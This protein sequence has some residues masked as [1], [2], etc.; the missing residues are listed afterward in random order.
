MID[1][2]QLLTSNSQ[3]ARDN[4]QV[5]VAEISRGIKGLALELKIPIIVM[6]QINRK[7]EEGNGEPQL[8][9]LRESGSIEQ[10][11]DVVI[12]LSREFKGGG[13]VE[14]ATANVA[15]QR[16]GPT[17]KVHLGFDK[18]ITKFKDWAYN[19]GRDAPEP[20]QA[21]KTKH[22]RSQGGNRNYE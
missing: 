8:H 6:A 7:A 3:K 2:L 5:E 11:A 4:R 15:K 17:D 20:K 21:A 12:L 1:Y 13:G 9:H 10:D 14:K 19:P 16:N 22:T 18:D